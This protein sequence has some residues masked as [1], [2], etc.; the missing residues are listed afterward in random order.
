MNLLDL[1]YLCK[2][3]I[4]PKNVYLEEQERIS[5]LLLSTADLANDVSFDFEFSRVVPHRFE[6]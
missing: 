1:P 2:G 5:Y 6:P 4:I 3:S